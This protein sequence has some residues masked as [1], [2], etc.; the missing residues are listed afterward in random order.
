MPLGRIL[1]CLV[2][3]VLGGLAAFFILCGTAYACAFVRQDGWIVFNV[4]LLGGIP[5]ILIG[6]IGTL[7]L[8]GIWERS[9]SHRG[10]D[11]S[12]GAREERDEDEA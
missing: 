12:A 11:Q 6:A 1:L 10:M 5:A 3:M 2:A 4:V 8:L 7:F 9:R